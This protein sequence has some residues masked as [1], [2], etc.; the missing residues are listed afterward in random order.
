MAQPASSERASFLGVLQERAARLIDLLAHPKGSLGEEDVWRLSLGAAFATLLAVTRSIFCVVSACVLALAG[1]EESADQDEPTPHLATATAGPASLGDWVPSDRGGSPHPDP[2]TSPMADPDTP[3]P[4]NAAPMVTG[5]VRETMVAAGYDY[6]RVETEEGDRWVAAMN[7]HVEVGDRIQAGGIVMHD[8]HSNS[9]DRT[10]DQ[11]VLA[12]NVFVIGPD[13][14]PVGGAAPGANPHGAMPGASPH[15]PMPGAAVPGANPHG[16][17][18][19]AV[20]GA[21]PHGAMP[22]AMPGAATP[23]AANPH[24]AMGASP[25]GAGGAPPAAHGAGGPGT[26]GHP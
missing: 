13:G 14:L 20:P 22:G 18:P 16:P 11:I 1:C 3:A 7:A 2:S 15:G 4:P 19:G 17:M 5:T 26:P 12:S 6:M 21:N 10:F 24:G 9:L 25:H 8:F 23:G